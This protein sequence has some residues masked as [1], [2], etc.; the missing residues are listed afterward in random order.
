M[1]S[2]YDCFRLCKPILGET[3]PVGTVG[4]VLMVFRKPSVA[5]EVE[6]PDDTGRNLGSQPT[7]TLTEEFMESVG[8]GQR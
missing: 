2:E 3:I 5:Y 8:D 1:F 7:F 6:F 4:V